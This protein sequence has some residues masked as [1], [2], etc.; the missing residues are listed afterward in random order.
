[1]MSSP[2]FEEFC[3][4]Y[5]HQL[6]HDKELRNYFSNQISHKVWD[7]FF[8]LA[9]TFGYFRLE[10]IPFLPKYR[11]TDLVAAQVACETLPVHVQNG[12][13]RIKGTLRKRCVSS[14]I[15]HC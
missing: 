3:Q 6:D 15:F 4:L 12:I 13:F 9:D 11:L 5:D 14:S 10:D 2:V 7:N 1:M 8:R